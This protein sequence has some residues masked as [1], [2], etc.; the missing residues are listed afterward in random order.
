[1]SKSYIAILA[2][3]LVAALLGMAVAEDPGY[4]LIAWR[5]FSIETSVWVGVGLLLAFWLLLL[6]VRVCWWL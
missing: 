5:N 6:L 4:I 2:V 3:L 1:M